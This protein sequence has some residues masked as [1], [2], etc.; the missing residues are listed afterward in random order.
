MTPPS[1]RSPNRNASK[2]ALY[3]QPGLHHGADLGVAVIDAADVVDDPG[4]EKMTP[5]A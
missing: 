5:A 3:K 2:S 1:L 4:R